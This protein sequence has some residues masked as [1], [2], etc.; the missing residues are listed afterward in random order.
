MNKMSKSLGNAIFLYDSAKEVQKKINKITMRA[1]AGD[2]AGRSGVTCW[3]STATRSCRE[4]RAEAIRADYAAG[5]D[6]MHGHMKAEL[7]AAINTL[8]AADAG[9]AGEAGGRRG[10]RRRRR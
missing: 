7:A 4:E 1:D 3:C 10:M 6:V 9:A 2:E 5:K 8:L